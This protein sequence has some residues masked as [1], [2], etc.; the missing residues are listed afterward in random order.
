MS[1]VQAKIMTATRRH[2][3]PTAQAILPCAQANALLAYPELPAFLASARLSS[4]Q[5]DPLS[6]EA[7]VKT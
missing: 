1:N 4:Q 7:V 5:N 2:Y 6:Q 3:A